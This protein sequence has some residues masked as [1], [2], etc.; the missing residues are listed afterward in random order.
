MSDFGD[1]IE[2]SLSDRAATLGA[3]GAMAHMRNQQRQTEELR[4]QRVLLEEQA[5]AA[6]D[7]AA[8][9]RERLDIE[10]RRLALEQKELEL[11]REEAAQ[12][13]ELRKLMANLSGELDELVA[14]YS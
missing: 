6:K 5:K 1:R 14:R 2:N 8:A 10:K 12:V 9:E 3:I 7:K 13:K 4:K 11:R